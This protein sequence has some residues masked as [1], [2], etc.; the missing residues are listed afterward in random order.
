ML[1]KLM[2]FL[3]AALAAGDVFTI[4]DRRFGDQ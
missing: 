2:M 1:I 4:D 3:V